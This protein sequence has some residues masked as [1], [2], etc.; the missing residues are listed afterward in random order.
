MSSKTHTK[1]AIIKASEI[2]DKLSPGSRKGWKISYFSRK[3]E[4]TQIPESLNPELDEF[5]LLDEEHHNAYQRLVIILQWICMIRKA[6]I[7]FAVYSLNRFN[8]APRKN[9]LKAVI[10]IFSYL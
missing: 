1:E 2:L 6:D 10:W 8:A 4:K 9:Q 7:Q 3:S 5:E